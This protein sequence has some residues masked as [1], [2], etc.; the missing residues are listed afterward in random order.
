MFSIGG[1]HSHLQ[2]RQLLSDQLLI[3]WLFSASP[4]PASLLSP[5][6]EVWVLYSTGVRW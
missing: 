6:N 4:I 5:F 3:D 2:G 1:L